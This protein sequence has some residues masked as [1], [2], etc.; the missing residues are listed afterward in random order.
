[1]SH[2][3]SVLLSERDGSIAGPRL[4]LVIISNVAH[5]EV[6]ALVH[7]GEYFS[8]C[9]VN[10]TKVVRTKEDSRVDSSNNNMK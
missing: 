6:I 8:V 3:S 7:E 5:F 10:I 1:M 2:T 4:V 9:L